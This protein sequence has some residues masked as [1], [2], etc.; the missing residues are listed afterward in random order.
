MPSSPTCALLLLSSLLLAA[1]SRT[2]AEEIRIIRDVPYLAAERSERLDLYLPPPNAEPAPAAVW[3]HGRRGD[4][5]E[6]RGTEICRVLALAGFVCVSINHGPDPELK[7]NLLDCKNAVRFL[8]HHAP[9]Y[10]LDPNRIAV[11]GGSMGG[12]YALLVGFTA[13]RVELEPEVP[14]PEESS[15]VRAVVDF[16]GPMGPPF[17]NVTDFVAPDGPPVLVLHGADDERVPIAQSEQ[18][19]SVLAAQGVEHEFVRVPAAGHAFRLNTTW[20]AKPLATDLAPVLVT[21]LAKHLAPAND[22]AANAGAA[23]PR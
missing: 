7:S 10:H 2:S 22:P 14:Y 20:D 11:M 5:G 4:K 12:F 6:A 3:I 16:Y 9:E 8:R 1:A 13:G 17:L 19:V 15:R 18:L 21:F 23:R